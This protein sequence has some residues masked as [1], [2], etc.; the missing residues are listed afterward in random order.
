MSRSPFAR[1]VKIP[2]NWNFLNI[3][4]TSFSTLKIARKLYVVVKSS[5][6]RTH[7]VLSLNA[8]YTNSPSLL[9]AIRQW[10]I[11]F[12]HYNIIITW[13]TT[14]IIEC[15]T[16]KKKKFQ[17]YVLSV[18]K[19]HRQ[20]WPTRRTAAAL[21]CCL[22]K[23]FSRTKLLFFPLCKSQF[24]QWS[25]TRRQRELFIHENLS[26]SSSPLHTAAAAELKLQCATKR[27]NHN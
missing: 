25:C 5:H 6:S 26:T 14:N 24:S 4:Y 3:F 11:I 8:K 16:N 1:C 10:F 20:F 12:I 15:E 17:R 7:S 9:L 13:Y 19:S 27:K 2:R 18:V 23:S 21:F 22:R